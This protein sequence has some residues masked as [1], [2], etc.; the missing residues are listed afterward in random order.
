MTLSRGSG[1]QCRK[2]IWASRKEA[3]AALK[4]GA[5]IRVYRCP[6]GNWHTTS[7]SSVAKTRRRQ[8]AKDKG[9]Q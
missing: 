8:L 1:C 6:A 5:G 7:R 9:N 2:I 3:L 4:R